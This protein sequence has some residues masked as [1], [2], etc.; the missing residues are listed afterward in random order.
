M[1]KIILYDTNIFLFKVDD[2]YSNGLFNN[3]KMKW[4][5]FISLQH[6]TTI[7]L[8]WNAVRF[9]VTAMP[10]HS[11]ITSLD[12]VPPAVLLVTTELS[13]KTVYNLKC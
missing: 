6:A 7:D 5:F 2:N 4:I 9:V 1:Y 13:V 3:D 12:Y 11:V 8:V 10:M